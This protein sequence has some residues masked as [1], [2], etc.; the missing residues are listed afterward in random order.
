MER[1]TLQELKRQV[2][3]LSRYLLENDPQR[4][5]LELR[6]EF[7]SRLMVKRGSRAVA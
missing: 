2:D 6:L 1:L 4:E 3:E 5:E 7:L